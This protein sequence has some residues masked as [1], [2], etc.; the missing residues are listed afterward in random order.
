MLAGIV[1]NKFGPQTHVLKH[2]EAG[3]PDLLHEN[4]QAF[5]KNIGD[6]NNSFFQTT[7]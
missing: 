7:C 6:G 1:S 2:K 5:F 3:R 4:L